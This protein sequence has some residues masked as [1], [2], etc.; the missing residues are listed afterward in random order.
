MTLYHYFQLLRY[1]AI[2]LYSVC[3]DI[4]GEHLSSLLDFSIYA[5][6]SYRRTHHSQCVGEMNISTQAMD[7]VAL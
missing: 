2:K 4:R 6:K 1:C 7:P 5:L 3:F